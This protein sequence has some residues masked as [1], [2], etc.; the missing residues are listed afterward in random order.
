MFP[1]LFA[2]IDKP[3]LAAA[4]IDLANYLTREKLAPEHPGKALSGPLTELLGSS[5]SRWR[6]SRK[7][8]EDFAESPQRSVADAAIACRSRF[9]CAT[10]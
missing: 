5:R 3:Q 4:V 9:R 1:K 6:S 7:R 8:P 2:A 10:V